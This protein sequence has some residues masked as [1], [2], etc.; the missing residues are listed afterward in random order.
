[1]PG[2]NRHHVWRGKKS[3]LHSLVNSKV[4]LSQLFPLKKKLSQKM[5]HR[6]TL[7][8]PVDNFP[9][10]PFPPFP[11]LARPHVDEERKG[12]EEE[13]EE[14]ECQRAK[15]DSSPLYLR[16]FGQRRRR[17]RRNCLCV[18]GWRERGR[19]KGFLAFGLR[20]LVGCGDR[21][22]RR[23]IESGEEITGRISPISFPQISNRKQKQKMGITLSRTIFK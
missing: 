12:K 14:G 17:R 6:T 16:R 3:F 5:Q 21:R 10:F 15:E 9:H 20:C 4:V 8:F 22:R 19:K 18:W 7:A 11:H 23:R 2:V 1:M 13:E